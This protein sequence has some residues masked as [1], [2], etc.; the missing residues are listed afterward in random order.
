MKM[1]PVVAALLLSMVGAVSGAYAQTPSISIS[2]DASGK[3][4]TFLASQLTISKGLADMF[5]TVDINL[6]TCKLVQPFKEGDT[7]AAMAA[8]D[9]A[10]SVTTVPLSVGTKHFQYPIMAEVKGSDGS[11]RGL[12]PA[13]LTLKTD[14]KAGDVLHSNDFDIET[15]RS[16]KA[17][18]SIPV[19]YIQGGSGMW[20]L[21]VEAADAAAPMTESKPLFTAISISKDVTPDNRRATIEAWKTVNDH[22]K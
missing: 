15:K 3:S 1:K 20:L 22:A 4:R 10:W 19:L 9:Q 16:F 5:A 21:S 11:M 17:G 14:I 8:Q 13:M 2:Q 6:F 12:S 7:I 18:D